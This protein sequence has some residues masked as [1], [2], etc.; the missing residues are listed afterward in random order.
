MKLA[1]NAKGAALV[2]GE[3]GAAVTVVVMAAE[4]V[5][6]AVAT[7][8]AEEE[9]AAVVAEEAIAATAADMEAVEADEI[10]NQNFNGSPNSILRAL[11]LFSALFVFRSRLG[12]RAAARCAILQR[13]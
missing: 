2:V 9:D 6:A 7:V 3:A 8:V 10:A 4:V 13:R 5:A 1:R 11:R 12:C